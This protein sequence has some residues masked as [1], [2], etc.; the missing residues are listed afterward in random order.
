MRDVEEVF[1]MEEMGKTNN[2]R[3]LTCHIFSFLSLQKK[4]LKIT[5]YTQVSHIFIE[6]IHSS[7]PHIHIHTEKLLIIYVYFESCHLQESYNVP[8]EVFVPKTITQV[9]H[10]TCIKLLVDHKGLKVDLSVGQKHSAGEGQ[11]QAQKKKKR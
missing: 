8:Q 6:R 4:T 3:C 11:H 9:L 1:I 5:H 2:K 10:C 7:P